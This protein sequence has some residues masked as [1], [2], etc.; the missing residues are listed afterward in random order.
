MGKSS[1]VGTRFPKVEFSQAQTSRLNAVRSIE[2]SRLHVDAL[3]PPPSACAGNP[4]TGGRH[5]GYLPMAEEGP[6]IGLD[7]EAP[8]LLCRRFEVV[9]GVI[10]KIVEQFSACDRPLA[11]SVEPE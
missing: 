1:A 11:T 2:I 4:S 7:Y 10:E 3:R 8:D 6:D 5:T 9:L